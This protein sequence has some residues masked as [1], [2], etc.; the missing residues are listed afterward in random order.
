MF[1]VGKTFAQPKAAD[2]KLFVKRIK[3][4]RPDRARIPL[5]PKSA[6]SS[7]PKSALPTSASEKEAAPSSHAQPF[8]NY[9]CGAGNRE[10]GD[11]KTFN[12]RASTAVGFILTR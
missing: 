3:P 10:L 11:K 1:T 9:G 2:D 4:Q 12:V 5:R 6:P 8:Y 7:R